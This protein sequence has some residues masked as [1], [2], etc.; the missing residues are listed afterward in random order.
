MTG[1]PHGKKVALRPVEPEDHPLLRTWQNDPEVAHWMDYRLQF[2]LRDIEEDQQ[3]ARRDGRPFVITLEDRPI[4]KCGLNQ[5]RWEP[6]V[7]AMYVYIGDKQLWGQGLGRD[8]VMALLA[9]AF[10]ECGLERVELTMLADN[11]RAGHVYAS[12]GFELEGRLAGRSYRGGVWHDTAIMSVPKDRF[13]A[14]RAH[15]GI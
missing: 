9:V 8:A 6:R 12:C 7:C 11:S 13:Q 5:F 2:S 4:G 15:Y 3:R 10:D 14:A 1:G